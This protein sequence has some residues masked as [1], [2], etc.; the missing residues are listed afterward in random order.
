M[1]VEGRGSFQRLL[2]LCAVFRS[3]LKLGNAGKYFCF[4]IILPHLM[5][6]AGILTCVCQHEEKGKELRK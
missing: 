3:Y 2:T 4:I 6:L 5:H 1:Q